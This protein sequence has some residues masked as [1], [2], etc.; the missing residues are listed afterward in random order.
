LTHGPPPPYSSR[1]NKRSRCLKLGPQYKKIAA[2]ILHAIEISL[3]SVTICSTV[4]SVRHLE[5]LIVINAHL[6]QSVS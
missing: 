4:K 6:N 5:K 2:A 3:L 1:L